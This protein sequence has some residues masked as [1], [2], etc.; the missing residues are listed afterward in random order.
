MA[1][2]ARSSIKLLP[3]LQRWS[4]DNVLTP[5]RNT[6]QHH[7]LRPKSYQTSHNKNWLCRLTGLGT[8]LSLC[9]KPVLVPADDKKAKLLDIDPNS[10][11]HSSLVRNASTVAVDA[12]SALVSQSVVAAIELNQLYVKYVNELITL[13]ESH[14]IHM[15]IPV[16]EYIWQEIIDFRVKADDAK[17][18]AEEIEVVLEVAI[19]VLEYAGEAAYQAGSEVYSITAGQRVTLA[20]SQLEVARTL[21]QNTLQELTRIQELSIVET[22]KRAEQNANLAEQEL[23]LA[24]Q[25]SEEAQQQPPVMAGA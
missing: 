19:R 16:E 3:C 23:K 13:Y 2:S 18:A 12:A 25:E 7:L 5:L 24:E 22:S 8:G 10:L 14:I 1:A 6:A 17:R 21:S 4:I 20:Q 11:T 15:G 9:A